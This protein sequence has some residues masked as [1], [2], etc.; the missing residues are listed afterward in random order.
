MQKH[1]KAEHRK[2]V[3]STWHRSDCPNDAVAWS[4]GPSEHPKHQPKNW[5]CILQ[6]IAQLGLANFVQ[7]YFAD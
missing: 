4:V 2:L 1:S 5:K 3:R 6:T 7:C